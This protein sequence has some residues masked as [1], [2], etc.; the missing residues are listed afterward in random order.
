MLKN[1]LLN[2]VSAIQHNDERLME[3]L[4]EVRLNQD[5]Q[6]ESFEKAIHFKSPDDETLEVLRP[7]GQENDLALE[8][9]VLRVGRP[10]LT[11]SHDEAVLQ[12][13]DAESQVWK[14]RLLIAKQQLISAAKA[15][16][17]IELQ[18]DPFYEWVGTGWLID[19][20][21]VVTN[22]HV[23]EVFGKNKGT[24]FVFRQ[25]AGGKQVE[26]F[27][28][29]LQEADCPDELTFKIISIL[30]IEDEIGPDMAFLRVE[31]SDKKAISAPISLF[32]QLPAINLSVA[33]I[34]YPARDSRI[35]DQKLMLDIFGDV[36]DKKRLAPGQIIG[37]SANELL[38]DCSTLGGNSGSV[39][40]DLTTGM[41]VGLHFA[42]KFLEKNFAVPSAVIKDRL[43]LFRK[44]GY[45]NTAPVKTS[46]A[47]PEKD[48]S[49]SLSLQKSDAV[50]AGPGTATFTVPLQVSISL[51]AGV[52]GDLSVQ[53]HQVNNYAAAAV[54]KSEQDEIIV[55]GVPEDYENRKG[56]DRDFL[57]NEHGLPLPEIIDEHL[58]DDILKYNA[59]GDDEMVLTYQH[60]SV[61]MSTSR[62]QC[63]FSAVNIDGKTSVPMARGPWRL[64][65]R[66][67]KDAQIIKECYGSAPKFSRG[68]MTR[69]EDP[70]WGSSREAIEGNA[71][72]MHVTNTVPQMQVMNAGIWLKLENYALQNARKDDMRIS[73]FTGPVFKKGDPVKY[74]VIIPLAF[75]KVIAFIHDKTGELCATGYRI[76]Q[77]EFLVDTEFVFGAH[78]TRQV[79][80]SSIEEETG[81]SFG[82]LSQLDPFDKG[83]E[84]QNGFLRNLD[85]I[86]FI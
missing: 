13:A 66:I 67:P 38:H 71:D 24:G 83:Q 21:I 73:V 43:E 86:K 76:S 22:R 75:W 37:S 79:A 1:R 40:I 28:D 30:H 77:E 34:G 23:A 35:S 56:Y 4:H 53:L 5:F 61:I 59:G 27:I 25:G 62:R 63:F 70:I 55:E 41:A 3:E 36:Y 45:K 12:F 85:Q 49:A 15:V 57:G 9:I 81:L 32:T 31:L 65:P 14:E 72:S 7:E 8:T 6:K 29:F 26:A 60:F 50:L 58:R 84:T 18:N 46:T 33:V 52:I 19:E 47:L 48:F 39:V 69:R 82:T 78:E 42:G 20:S 16:G 44:N 2:A 68:H 54:Q 80:I 64:D 51:G 10:V 17:K 11:I 74:G